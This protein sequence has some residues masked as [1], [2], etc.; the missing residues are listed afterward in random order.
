MSMNISRAD[1]SITNAMLLQAS[2]ISYQLKGLTHVDKYAR[3][4]T[5]CFDES[6]FTG[7]KAM[8]KW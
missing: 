8:T 5:S 3:K 4:C 1:L 7:N 6:F 2:L